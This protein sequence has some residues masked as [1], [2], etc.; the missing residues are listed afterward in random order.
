MASGV[1]SEGGVGLRGT[2][3]V[4]LKKR[5]CGKG[6]AWRI[7]QSLLC[8]LQ[9]EEENL[10]LGSGIGIDCHYYYISM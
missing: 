3:L 1:R 6:M 8:D 7:Y 5:A 2:V 4:A 9:M 10:S